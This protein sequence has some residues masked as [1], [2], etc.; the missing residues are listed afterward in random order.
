MSIPDNLDIIYKIGELVV[1][2]GGVLI[3]I[4][5]TGRDLFRSLKV[6]LSGKQR[7]FPIL[8]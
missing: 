1:V 6:L 4:A 5:R 2:G 8:K 7:R 3:A